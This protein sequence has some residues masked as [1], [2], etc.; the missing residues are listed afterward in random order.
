MEFF[1]SKEEVIDL[2]LTQFGRHL[3]SKGKFKPVYYSFFDDDVQTTIS[4]LVTDALAKKREV[5]VLV[6]EV[7]GALDESF[8]ELLQVCG[9]KARIPN[10]RDGT[11]YGTSRSATRS[12]RA[13]HMRMMSLAIAISI[14]VAIAEYSSAVKSDLVSAAPAGAGVVRARGG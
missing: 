1:D 13:H 5:W 8:E 6:A 12:F 7:T 2:Q 11:R 4:K 10:H 3:L 9:A 14:A